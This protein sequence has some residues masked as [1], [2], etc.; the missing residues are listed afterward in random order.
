[1]FA[2]DLAGGDEPRRGHDPLDLDAELHDLSGFVA[3]DRL[4]VKLVEQTMKRP[5]QVLHP[6]AKHIFIIAGGCDR[7]P[8]SCNGSRKK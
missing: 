8:L 5:Q 3:V 4:G 7:K 1:V 2:A 6:S